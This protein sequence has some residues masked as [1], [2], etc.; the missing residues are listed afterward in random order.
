MYERVLNEDQSDDKMETIWSKYLEFEC[1]V[2]DLQSMQ[3]VK[4]SFWNNLWNFQ[5]ENRRIEKILHREA[6]EDTPKK[7]EGRKESALL[8]DR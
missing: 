6:T 2:G 3:K 8:I 7:A 1:N 4:G 5:V